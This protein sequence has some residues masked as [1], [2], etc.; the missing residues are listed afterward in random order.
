[1]S[2]AFC[3]QCTKPNTDTSWPFSDDS[4]FWCSPACAD[5][6]D[7]ARPEEAARGIKLSDM[8][9]ERI[10]ALFERSG[11]DVPSRCPS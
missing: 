10:E 2:D 5:T 3:A 4:T 11:L 1:M 8:S 9:I 6:W 7:L